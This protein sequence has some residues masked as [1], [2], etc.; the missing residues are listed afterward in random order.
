MVLNNLAIQGA[1]EEAHKPTKVCQASNIKPCFYRRGRGA[2]S[3]SKP[4]ELGLMKD[5]CMKARWHKKHIGDGG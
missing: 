1:P 5:L 3:T 2:L 4:P